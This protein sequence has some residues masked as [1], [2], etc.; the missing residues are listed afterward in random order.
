MQL[1]EY[2][3]DRGRYIK[4]TAHITGGG[5]KGNLARILPTGM[6]AVI[7]TTT[8]SVPPLF[9]LLASLGNLSQEELYRTFNMGIGMIIVLSPKGALEARSLLPELLTIGK[10]TRGEGVV[11]Q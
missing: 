4:G 11:M 3:A 1:R 7:D 5:F 2:L 10:I 9:K 8:W 6:Q